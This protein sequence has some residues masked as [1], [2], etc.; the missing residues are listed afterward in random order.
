[1]FPDVNDEVGS[2]IAHSSEP[3]CAMVPF[4]FSRG[5]NAT[6]PY[7]VLFPIKNMAQG[8]MATRDFVPTDLQ[9]PLDRKAYLTAFPGRIA[10][11]D[12]IGSED[13]FIDAYEVR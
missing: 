8:E 7:S 2:A 13:E 4:I 3:N 1:M 5:H 12:E 6:I 10:N 11:E 9:E